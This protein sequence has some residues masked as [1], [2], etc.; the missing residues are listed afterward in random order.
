M[1]AQ[2]F[3]PKLFA[4]LRELAEHNDRAWFAANKERY[5]RDVRTP[6]LRFI[7][8]FSAPL[9]KIAPHLVADPRPV[10]QRQQSRT[11]IDV[12]DMCGRHIPDSAVPEDKVISAFSGIKIG[13]LGLFWGTGAL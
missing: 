10:G 7:S 4:F 2:H 12:L 5:E 6:A 13:E 1:P 9:A 3:T 8:D 11:V